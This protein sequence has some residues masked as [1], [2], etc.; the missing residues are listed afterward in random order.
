MWGYNIAQQCVFKHDGNMDV[1]FFCL[2][3]IRGA[4]GNAMVGTLGFI[5]V[6]ELNHSTCLTAIQ[7]IALYQR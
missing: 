5:K 4:I 6:S 1:V 2:L 3:V 7:L